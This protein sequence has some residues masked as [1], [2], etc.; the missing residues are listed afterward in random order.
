MIGDAVWT[1]RTPETPHL[2]QAADVRQAFASYEVKAGKAP[3]H[4]N[5]APPSNSSAGHAPVA[6]APT[7]NITVALHSPRGAS[8]SAPAAASAASHAPAPAP[9]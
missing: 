8:A 4:G 7:A 5:H 3:Q 9:R 1:L 2:L 6:G